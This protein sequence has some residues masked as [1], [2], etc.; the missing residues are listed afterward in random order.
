MFDGIENVLPNVTIRL[1]SIDFAQGRKGTSNIYIPEGI[2]DIDNDIGNVCR[3]AVAICVGIDFS[4]I[5]SVT[6]LPHQAARSM[7]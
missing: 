1:V 5:S 7:I 2:E 4:A 3:G 6:T